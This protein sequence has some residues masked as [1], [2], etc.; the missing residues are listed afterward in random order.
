MFNNDQIQMH[1][2]GQKWVANKGVR[3][4]KDGSVK[5]PKGSLA[6]QRMTEAGDSVY[7]P[8]KHK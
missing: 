4:V 5:P 3:G 1:F 7:D 8:K 2:N 6:R